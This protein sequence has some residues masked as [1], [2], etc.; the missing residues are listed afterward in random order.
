MTFECGVCIC[1]DCKKNYNN[2]QC[3]KCN[4]CGWSENGEP[5]F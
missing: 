1:K 4:G 5:S 2:L 3:G